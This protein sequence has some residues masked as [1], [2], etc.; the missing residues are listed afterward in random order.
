MPLRGRWDWKADEAEILRF[1]NGA[2]DATGWDIFHIQSEV[3][4]QR[5]LIAEARKRL[6]YSP[7]PRP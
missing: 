1:W 6:G 2:F 7:R 5:Y 4:N 3:P